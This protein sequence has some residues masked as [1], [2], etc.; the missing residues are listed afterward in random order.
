MSTLFIGVILIFR[1]IGALSLMSTLFIG[2]ILMARIDS[3][4]WQVCIHLAH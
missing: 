3:D 4:D 1:I 2:V